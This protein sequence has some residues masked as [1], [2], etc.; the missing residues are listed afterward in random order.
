MPDI[1]EYWRNAIIIQANRKEFDP[2][3]N[4]HYPQVQS[5]FLTHC[6]TGTGTI[7]INSREFVMNSGAVLFAPWNHSITYHPDPGNPFALECVHLIPD[8]EERGD[9]QYIA[10]HAV[11]SV[12]PVY[13]LRHN[14][15]VDKFNLAARCRCGT[16]NP[17]C[18][19]IGYAVDIYQGQATEEQMR[20]T[21]RLLFFEVYN[22]LHAS[23]ES[24]FGQ[25]P[26][27][28]QRMLEHIDDYLE[29]PI[30]MRGLSFHGKMSVPSIYRVFRKYLHTTPKRYIIDRRLRYAAKMLRESTLQVSIMARNLQFSNVGNFSRA[31]KAKFGVSPRRYRESPP[32][33]EDPDR[34][35]R[36]PRRPAPKFNPV[37][38]PKFIPEENAES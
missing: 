9:V 32:D 38:H 7:R 10:F 4:F 23:A 13:Q 1:S 17:L 15:F 27:S 14:E 20:L 29:M 21:A 31:F 35:S 25:Y 22:M 5:C 6:V 34:L 3:E 33:G 18:K 12:H 16:E 37:F 28:L 8:T 2:G 30:Q 19:L 11:N 36:E 26:P 24:L